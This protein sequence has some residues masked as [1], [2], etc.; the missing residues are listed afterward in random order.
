L[1]YTGQLRAE[2]ARAGTPVGAYGAMIAG[3]A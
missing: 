2:L 1:A 3:H